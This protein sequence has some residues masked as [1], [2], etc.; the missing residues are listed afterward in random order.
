M[1]WYH[2]RPNNLVSDFT[3]L[4][5][6]SCLVAV[7]KTLTADDDREVRLTELEDCEDR[8]N[9]LVRSFG[10]STDSVITDVAPRSFHRLQSYIELWRLHLE[11]QRHEICA[12]EEHVDRM[13]SSAEAWVSGLDRLA[14]DGQ[15]LFFQD[16]FYVFFT[17]AGRALY[18]VSPL[19]ACFLRSLID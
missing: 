1:N 16:G 17:R 5:F 8:F 6:R 2:C 14:A 19:S 13:F 3:L 4:S 7:T 15:F 12:S 18:R 9:G 11:A 10:L